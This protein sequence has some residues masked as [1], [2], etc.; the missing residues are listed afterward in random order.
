MRYR[1]KTSYTWSQNIAYGVGL[2]ASD[3][4]L[5]SDGRHLDL[6][7]NDLEQLE[8][9]SKALGRSLPISLK[10]NRSERQAYRIQFSEVSYYDFLLGVGLTP[11]K[12]K[13]IGPLLVPDEYYV[14]FLRGYFDGDGTVYG[15][16][17]T[18]WK[19]SFMYYTG[20]TSASPIFID[21]LRESNSR[22]FGISKGHL[23]PS[24]GAKT[25]MYAK[26]DSCVLFE[27]IYYKSGLLCL[28]RKHSKFVDLIRS[29]PYADSVLLARVV[30]L[31]NTRP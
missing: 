14:D 5:L 11:A 6:T 21:W 18:R 20:F 15:F 26:Q 28:G 1:H 27:K 29:D 30:K 24:K 4:C 13:T 19:N 22:L 12:S 9:F 25:L 31:V 17:D 3:G 7:S 23:K 16:R 10:R 2:M 8:N